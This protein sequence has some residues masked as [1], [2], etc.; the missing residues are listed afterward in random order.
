MLISL[1]CQVLPSSGLFLLALT[2]LYCCS[3][4]FIS[5]VLYYWSLKKSFPWYQSGFLLLYYYTVTSFQRSLDGFSCNYLFNVHVP[6]YILSVMTA[7][8]RYV[9]FIA[10]SSAPGTAHNRCLINICC[11]T[12]HIFQLELT[13]FGASGIVMYWTES[14]LWTV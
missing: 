8:K 9:L 2:L 4:L 10:V 11:I 6:F 1:V 3:L 12:G 13:R 7:V 5:W 14:G